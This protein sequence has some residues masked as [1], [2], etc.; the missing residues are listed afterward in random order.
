MNRKQKQIDKLYTELQEVLSEVY[1]SK[2]Y[3]L[4]DLEIEAELEANQ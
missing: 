1:L 4:V 3:K 2:I